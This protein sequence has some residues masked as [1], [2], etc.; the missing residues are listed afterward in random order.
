MSMTEKAWD[1][2]YEWKAV[3][4]LTLGFGLVGLDRWIVAPLFPAIL[5]DLH[6]NYQDIGNIV[7]ALGLA[8]GFFAI[9]GGGLSDRLGRKRVLIP[10]I[11]VFSLL[12]GISGLTQGLLSLVLIRA[13]MGVSEGTFCPTS[14][15]T[16]NDASKPSRRG[17]NLG[18]QQS[19]FPL[20]GLALGPILATQLLQ[21][22]SWRW[23][24]VLVAVPGLILAVLLAITIRE[25][26]ELKVRPPGH[27]GGERAPLGDVLRHRNVWVGMI[28][29]F[30]AMC[31]IFTI[32][33]MMPNYLTDY[34]KLSTTQMGFVTSA[35]GFG[36]FL[37]QM[38]MPG[39]SDLVGRK[40]VAVLGFLIG[41]IFVYIFMH[42]GPEPLKLFTL[43]F[44]AA[45]FPFGLLGLITGPIAAE[46]A[47]RGLV[48]STTGIIVGSGEIFG[49]GIAPAIAGTIAQRF[50]IQ[51]TLM[52]A[53]A[54]LCLGVVVCLFL[55]ETAPRRIA[56][57]RR[58]WASQPAETGA[59]S[60]E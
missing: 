28:G 35:I 22:V 6:L 10:A 38:V 41:A 7:A 2:S 27:E 18:L 13:I 59:R 5:K 3:T 4:L 1:T 50:G 14:F 46:A 49:G 51:Y 24:F 16:V 40:I 23:V 31:G 57:G 54:G 34:L 26:H 12:S 43:L 52:M 9:V 48:S 58:V 30:C 42:T 32:S 20:F 25:P 60:L 56:G 21:V 19:T 39:I 15:A 37:G 8:W 44:V 45:F 55:H 36:G 33:A 47:P 11:V 17:F 53:L 29:L